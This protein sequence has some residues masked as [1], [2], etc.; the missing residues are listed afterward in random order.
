MLK[1][2]HTYI[3]LCADKT[4]Y[5]GITNDLIAREKRHNQGFGS[6]YTRTRLPIKIIY[7]EKF[8]TLKEAARREIEIKSLTRT[9]KLCLI[10]NKI[11]NLKI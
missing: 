5:T 3:A 4:L 9:K 6:K 10:N 11:S 7:F 2:Y 1:K 8:K